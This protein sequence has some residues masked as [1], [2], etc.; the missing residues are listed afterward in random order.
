MEVGNTEN[1]IAT[2]EPTYATNQNIIW[3]SDDESIVTVSDT[4]ILKAL[5]K[6]KT[7]ITATTVDG[8]YST[9]CE[10]TV[11]EKTNKED[12]VYISKEDQVEEGTEKIE[13]IDQAK[14]NIED[15]QSNV[16]KQSIQTETEKDNTIATKILPFTGK[17]IAILLL[18]FL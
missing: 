16:D 18:V 13:N 9:S 3:K 11:T 8:N 10:V 15:K 2:I 1:L 14:Q 17:G 12:D 5:K 7:T 4:G 6:G